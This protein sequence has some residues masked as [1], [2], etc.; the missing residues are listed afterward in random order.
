MIYKNVLLFIYFTIFS[1]YVYN[2]K[3][4]IN[5]KS[6]ILLIAIISCNRY[7]Y[8]NRTLLSLNNHLKLY[9]NNLRYNYLYVDQG[10][11]QREEIIYTFNLHNVVLMNPMGYALSFNVIF[12]YLYTKYILFLEEDWEIVNDI[13]KYLF[14]PSFIKESIKLLDKVKVVYG[15]LLRESPNINVD[16]SLII[17]TSMGKHILFVLNPPKKRY[18][19]I[20]GASIYRTKDLKRLNYYISE[21]L[22]SEFFR[23]NDYKLGFTYKGLKGDKNSTEKQYVMRHIGMNST[24][25]GICN[26]WLY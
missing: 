7:S 22:T 13:E 2:N 9:D 14:H 12:S 1:Y 20:N 21:W 6:S 17:N 15:I 19:F 24:R 16:Y 10:T 25:N 18:N 4:N 5:N 26:I 3:Y 23:K 11:I 8:L